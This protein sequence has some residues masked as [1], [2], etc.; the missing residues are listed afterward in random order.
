M[1]K[2]Q[3]SSTPGAVMDVERVAA[4]VGYVEEGMPYKHACALASIPYFTFQGWK[5]RGRDWQKRIAMG[6]PEPVEDTLDA[7]AIELVDLLEAAEA[8]G[9]RHHLKTIRRATEGTWIPSRPYQDTISTPDGPE[10][11]TRWTQPKYIAPDVRSAQWMLAKRHPNEFGDRKGTLTTSRTSNGDVETLVQ[12][13]DVDGASTEQLE[14]M[15]RAALDDD[16]ALKEG[17]IG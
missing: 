16:G 9:M 14:A 3:K 11:V 4:L 8:S 2:P 13:L 17:V 12:V 6:E 7:W 1:A 5:R 10:I 15:A